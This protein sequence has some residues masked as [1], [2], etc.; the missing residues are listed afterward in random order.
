[1]DQALLVGI[2]Q[3]ESD[4]GDD[5]DRFVFRHLA[6]A[7]DL[8]PERFAFDEFHDEIACLALPAEIESFDDIGMIDVASD[9]VFLLEA[10]ENNGVG[11]EMLGHDL[12]GDDFAG[13]AVAAPPPLQAGHR[14]SRL[15]RLHP[16]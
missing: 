11:Q 2:L 9:E 16:S 10:S 14:P 7:L 1:M 8:L 4:L 12:D 15:A 6:V 5:A 13:H 3:S